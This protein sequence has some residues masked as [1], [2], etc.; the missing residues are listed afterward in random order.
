ME[1]SENKNKTDVSSAYKYIVEQSANIT[2]CKADGNYTWIH[3]I[4]HEP[5]YVSKRLNILLNLLNMTNFF[6]CHKSYLVNI[7]HI[8]EIFNDGSNLMLLRDGKKINV[9]FRKLKELKFKLEGNFVTASN[10]MSMNN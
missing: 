9:A 5:L 1:I 4:N 8:K 10:Y 2:H 6:R 3:F 7:N